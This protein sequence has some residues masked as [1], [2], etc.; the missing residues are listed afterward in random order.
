MRRSVKVKFDKPYSS[1]YMSNHFHISSSPSLSEFSFVNH[2]GFPSYNP[3]DA[4][5][6]FCRLEPMRSHG[7]LWFLLFE[8]YKWL[9]S[10]VSPIG[11]RLPL[12]VHPHQIQCQCLLVCNI[13]FRWS[14]AHYAQTGLK[15]YLY[16][17]QHLLLNNIFSEK[18]NRKFGDRG[19]RWST[20]LYV[21]LNTIIL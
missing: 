14:I 17:L 4:Y 19:A 9:Q 6:V 8:R 21:L 20:L 2:N 3:Y 18:K 10:L 15:F 11:T 5:G 13:Y 12:Y 7:D 16:T 1:T